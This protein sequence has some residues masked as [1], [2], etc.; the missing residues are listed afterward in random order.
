MRPHSHTYLSRSTALHFPH[1]RRVGLPMAPEKCRPVYG[2]T[3]G[4]SSRAAPD[5]VTAQLSI[6]ALTSVKQVESLLATKYE[7]QKTH[8]M[9]EQEICR[10]GASLGL[11]YRRSDQ[12]HASSSLGQGLRSSRQKTHFPSSTK[13][14]A[15]SLIRAR[16]SIIA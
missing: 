4:T 10:Y 16:G 3:L 6:T 13:I 15:V 8:P 1:A 5:Q 11:I 7:L 14:K 9:T 12:A 2:F